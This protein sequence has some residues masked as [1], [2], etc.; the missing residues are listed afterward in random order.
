MCFGLDRVRRN[1]ITEAEVVSPWSSP[2][3]INLL[4]LWEMHM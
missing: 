1:V 3:E 2:L 4:R